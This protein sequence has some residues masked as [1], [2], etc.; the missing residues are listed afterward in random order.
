VVAAA[1]WIKHHKIQY[2]IAFPS[3]PKCAQFSSS[4][5]RARVLPSVAG[6]SLARARVLVAKPSSRDREPVQNV[7]HGLEPGRAEPVVAAF[8]I[9]DMRLLEADQAGQSVL[10]QAPALALGGEIKG[11]WHGGGEGRE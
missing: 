9:R 8:N 10:R 3:G 5:A 2:F 7:S 1:G 11:G 6:S 4:L